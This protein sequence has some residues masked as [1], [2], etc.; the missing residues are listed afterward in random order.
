MS[1]VGPE[2]ERAASMSISITGYPFATLKVI[3]LADEARKLASP[4]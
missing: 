1:T 4:E 3:G 2:P